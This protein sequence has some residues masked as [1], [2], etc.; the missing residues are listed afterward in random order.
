[1][2]LLILVLNKTEKLN[3]L[4]LALGN[5]GISGGTILDSTGMARMLYDSNIGIP[6]FSAINMMMSDGRP[7]NK[8]VFMVLDD[9]KVDTAKDTIKT[10]CNFNE[11]GVGVMF[12]L[13]VSSFEGSKK[14]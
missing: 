12:T 14:L 9:D 13:P 11:P 8:T 3:D 7:M 1:M 10:V 4:L 2:Q 6:F 5:N